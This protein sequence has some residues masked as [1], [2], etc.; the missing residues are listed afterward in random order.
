[1]CRLISDG[2]SLSNH[3]G[4]A[5]RGIMLYKELDKYKNLISVMEY[6]Q[7]TNRIAV[8]FADHYQFLNAYQCIKGNIAALEL[9]KDTYQKMADIYQMDSREAAAVYQSCGLAS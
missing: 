4:N 5:G 9:L 7:I 6:T 2:I 3:L 1:M 8:I